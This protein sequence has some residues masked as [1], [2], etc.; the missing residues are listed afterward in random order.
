MQNKVLELPHHKSQGVDNNRLQEVGGRLD[1]GLVARMEI[2]V[3]VVGRDSTSVEKGMPLN[4]G[5]ALDGENLDET[6]A[7]VENE[8]VAADPAALKG[9][10]AID[11]HFLLSVDVLSTIDSVQECDTEKQQKWQSNS[12]ALGVTA[13]QQRFV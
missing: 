11:P 1:L 10:D 6:N 8:V 7:N 2:D 9:D 12:R 5:S 4:A 13:C 3:E